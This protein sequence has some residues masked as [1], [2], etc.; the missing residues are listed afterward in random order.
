MG[1]KA[2]K[3]VGV[4]FIFGALLLSAAG[5]DEIR[6]IG[7]RSLQGEVLGETDTYVIFKMKNYGVIHLQKSKIVQ[8]APDGGLPATPTPV[9]LARPTPSPLPRIFT[10]RSRLDLDP[11]APRLRPIPLGGQ[12]SQAEPEPTPPP[13][14]QWDDALP[15]LLQKL[16]AGQPPGPDELPILYGVYRKSRLNSAGMSEVEKGFIAAVTASPAFAPM[17]QQSDARIMTEI[18]ALLEKVGQGEAPAD[19]ENEIIQA[20]FRKSWSNPSD[21][22]ELETMIVD[23]IKGT[24]LAPSA[25]VEPAAGGPAAGQWDDRLPA[26]LQKLATAQPPAP[27]ELPIMFG[28]YRKSRLNS[29]AMS[30]VEKSFMVSLKAS[31]AFGPMAQQADGMINASVTALLDKVANGEEPSEE[32]KGII[33]AAFTKSWSNPSELNELETKIVD[34]VKGTALAP[35]APAEAEGGGA[36]EGAAGDLPT[37]LSQLDKGAA[38]TPEQSQTAQKLLEKSRADPASLSPDEKKAL[39]LM[40]SAAEALPVPPPPGDEPATP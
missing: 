30:E 37:L 19:E 39:E 13:V 29:A 2:I 23:A 18:T 11:N 27:D 31:P 24:A 28:V 16:G 34:A 26:I 36:P 33:Q 17:A 6:L 1:R 38:L 35:S 14:G 22:N 4:G 32:E 40:S 15:G 20:A 9:P 25:P 10:T 7:G 21:L 8:V 5:A 12:V 3:W